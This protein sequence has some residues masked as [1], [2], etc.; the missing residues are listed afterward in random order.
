MRIFPR[1]SLAYSKGG[2]SEVGRGFLF[3]FA[4][5]GRFGFF[6]GACTRLSASACETL[7]ATVPRADRRILHDRRGGAD[8][9][10]GAA[11]ALAPVSLLAPPRPSF[12]CRHRYSRLAISRKIILLQAVFFA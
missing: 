7:A 12:P 9:E 2:A 8:E 5:E 3:N 10:T 6:F 11:R 4:R 1:T